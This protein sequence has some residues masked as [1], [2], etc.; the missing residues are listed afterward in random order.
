MKKMILLLT[1]IMI[2]FIFAGCSSGENE[3]IITGPT[4]IDISSV[5]ADAEY[6]TILIK[7]NG[8]A[9]QSRIDM[10]I[11][12]IVEKSVDIQ[13]DKGEQKIVKTESGFV[14]TDSITFKA[15]SVQDGYW[16][17]TDTYKL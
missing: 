14:T 15:Y 6:F 12:E 11:G 5:V 9:G 1:V 16:V 13:I 7:N 17:L 10:L 8:I 4:E 3:I 2:G